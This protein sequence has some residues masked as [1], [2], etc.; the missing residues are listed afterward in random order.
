M[1][2]TGITIIVVIAVLLIWLVTVYNG[3]VALRQ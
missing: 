3:L 2:W 1:S